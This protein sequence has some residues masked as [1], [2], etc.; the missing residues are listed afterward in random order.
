LRKIGRKGNHKVPRI[1]ALESSCQCCALMLLVSRDIPVGLRLC[2]RPG[3]IASSLDSSG[4]KAAQDTHVAV[5]LP[6]KR[7]EML[8]VIASGVRTSREEVGEVGDE[9]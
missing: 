6:M 5:R 9:D 7:R 4:D 3:H 8:A 2:E 1:E